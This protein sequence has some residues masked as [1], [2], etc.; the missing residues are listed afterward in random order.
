MPDLSQ[1]QPH[2]RPSVPKEFGGKW[3]AWNSDATRIIASAD[4]L[5][6]C[7]ASA[8]KAGESDAQFE[9][10]PRPDVRIIGMAR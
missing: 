4:T 3:I 2:R 8:A 1:G 10:V 6:N 9:K 7:A 5:K